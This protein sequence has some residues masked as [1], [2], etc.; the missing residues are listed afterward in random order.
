MTAAAG[1]GGR[2]V[3]A[4]NELVVLMYFGGQEYCQMVRE[5]GCKKNYFY[6]LKR[7]KDSTKANSGKMR[8]ANTALF[9][10]LPIM[11]RVYSIML[12]KDK[13]FLYR[14]VLQETAIIK[15]IC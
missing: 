8:T 11:A 10:A 12:A 9:L 15:A 6:H 2:V 14:L 7:V 4:M 5:M 3:G 1:E 13:C